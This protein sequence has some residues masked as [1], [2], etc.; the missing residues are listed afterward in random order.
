[1]KADINQFGVLEL[2]PSTVTEATAIEAWR[3]KAIVDYCTLYN[4]ESHAYRASKIRI[5][6]LETPKKL[7][8]Y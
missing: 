1:M 6:E 7:R 5:K 8:T 4:M 2:T 3:V